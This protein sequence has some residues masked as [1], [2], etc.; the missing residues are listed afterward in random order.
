MAVTGPSLTSAAGGPITVFPPVLAEAEP[1]FT[2]VTPPASSRI[3]VVE[4]EAAALG[5]VVEGAAGAGGEVDV[6][7]TGS[8]TWVRPTTATGRSASAPAMSTVAARASTPTTASAMPRRMTG[9]YGLST[10]TGSMS[11]AGVKPS[12]WP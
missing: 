9:L 11:S 5:L 3:T 10:T 8:G 4:R 6:V 1:E 2:T 7:T 12:T